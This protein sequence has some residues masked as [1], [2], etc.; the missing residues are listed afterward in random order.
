MSSFRLLG[1][2]RND[3]DILTCPHMPS[4]DAWLSSSSFRAN[5]LTYP[6]S[7]AMFFAGRAAHKRSPRRPP[8][9][10]KHTPSSQAYQHPSQTSQSNSPDQA[11]PTK[12]YPP[13]PLPTPQSTQSFRSKWQTP[14]PPLTLATSPPL[15]SSS[16]QN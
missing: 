5:V 2:T 1:K 3:R 15:A 10:T 9:Q 8:C 11:P 16:S 12:P 4:Q 13:T 6:H 14:S 7:K